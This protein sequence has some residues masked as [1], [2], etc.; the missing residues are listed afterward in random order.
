[1]SSLMPKKL[2]LTRGKGTHE[3]Q[4]VSFDLALR[5]AGLSAFNL[6]KVSSILPPR[7]AI[8]S[9][10]EG[11]RLLE[12][13]QIVFVVLSEIATNEP[14]QLIA[15]SIGMA[16]PNIFNHHGYLYEFKAVNMKAEEVSQKAEWLAAT[17]LANAFG[18]E[19]SEDSRSPEDKHRIDIAEG[20]HFRTE[21]ITQTAYGTKGKWTTALSAAVLVT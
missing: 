1:M 2:F 4:L 12:P 17:L 11:L 20:L 16:I 3:D 7:C 6:V 8:I 18:K 13:G 10:K 9:P 15:A 5:E 21:S 19:I 14:N